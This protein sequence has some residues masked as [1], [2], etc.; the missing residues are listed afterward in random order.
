MLPALRPGLHPGIREEAL[1]LGIEGP[2]T[3]GRDKGGLSAFRQVRTV[4]GSVDCGG[5]QRWWKSRANR[6]PKNRIDWKPEN[7]APGECFF[8][9]SANAKF[10]QGCRDLKTVIEPLPH[11]EATVHPR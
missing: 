3:K 6:P 2:V 9:R 1:R 10:T 8:K 11:Y 5:R 7:F 4:R